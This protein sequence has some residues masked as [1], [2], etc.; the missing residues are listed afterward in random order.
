MCVWLPLSTD[1]HVVVVLSIFPICTTN[2]R[3]L[4]TGLARANWL[5]QRCISY[6]NMWQYSVFFLFSVFCLSV[7]YSRVYLLM[8]YAISSPLKMR[9]H[10]FMQWTLS[11]LGR[12]KIGLDFFF[13]YFCVSM[14]VVS[15]WKIN[16]TDTQIQQCVCV[17][18]LCVYSHAH[19]HT[20]E[21]HNASQQ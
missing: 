8:R 10:R 5:V 7:C 19:E 1:F 21:I 20:K 3:L 12:T 9:E 11:F 15:G 16:R 2:H 4:L 17:F 18:V 6:W 13:I 14:V